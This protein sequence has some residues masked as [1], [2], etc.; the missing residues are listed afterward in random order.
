MQFDLWLSKAVFITDLLQTWL[1]KALFI[2]DRS[3][4]STFESISDIFSNALLISNLSIKSTAYFKPVFQKR[5]LIRTCLSKYCFF[6][7]RPRKIESFYFSRRPQ[8]TQTSYNAIKTNENELVTRTDKFKAK[9]CCMYFWKVRKVSL[10]L[11]IYIPGPWTGDIE[12]YE[13][14][15]QGTGEVVVCHS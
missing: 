5:C 13:A 14:R 3:F 10:C 15:P 9:L 7:T 6:Q 8:C 4:K 11:Y 2:S 12:V 1:L